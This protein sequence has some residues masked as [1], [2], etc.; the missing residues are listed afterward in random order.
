MKKIFFLTML[1]M[2]CMVFANAQRFQVTTGTS[3]ANEKWAVVTDTF[4]S[5]AT[6]YVAIGNT[7]NVDNFRQIWISSYTT[8]GVMVTSALASTGRQIIARDI[9][10]APLDATTGKRSYYVTGWTQQPGSVGAAA[11]NQMFVG[12]IRLDGSFIWYQE[13]PIS[14]NGNHIEGVAVVMAPNGDAVAVGNTY[15]PAGTITA[16]SRITLSRFSAAGAIL[17]SKVYNQSGN[18]MAR[19]I[20]MGVPTPNC[21]ASPTTLPGEFVVTGEANIATA[22][23]AGR[24]TA[25]VSAYNGAGTECWKNL[26]PATLTA[27][28]ITGD[29]GYDIVLNPATQNYAIA[30]VAQTGAVRASASSTPYLFEVTS[31][32]VITLGAVYLGPNNNPLGIYPRCIAVGAGF[33]NP[34]TNGTQLVIAG[35]DYGTNRTFMARIPSVGAVGSFNNYNG[36]AT[37]N[38]LAQPFILNDAQPEGILYSKLTSKPGYFVST[39]AHPVGAFGAGDAHFI[40]TDLNGQTPDDCKAL[41]IANIALSSKASTVAQSN[42]LDLQLW[43]T[44]TLFNQSLAVQQR[45]CNDVCNV[46]SAY[47]FTQSGSAVSFTGTGTGNGT[48]TYNWN[49]GDGSTSTLQN[50][51]HTYANGSFTACLTVINTNSAGDTCSETICKQITV[52]TQPCDVKASFTYKVTCKY[53]V[54]F[55]NTSTGTPTL[56]YKW[57]FGDGTFSTVKNPIKTF[58]NCGLH[59]V[60]LVTCN[61]ICCDTF[62]ATIDIPCCKVVSDFCLQDSGLYVK[63]LYSTTMNPSPTVYT[64]Y[65]DG[66]ATAWTAN[67]NKL[68]TAGL[69]TICLKASRSLCPGDTCCSTCCKTIAV[70]TPCTVKADFWYQVQSTGNVVFTNKST[71]TGY[72]SMWNFGDGSPVSTTA[73]PSHIYTTPGTYLVCLTSMIVNGGD[74]CTSRICK[75]IV[76]DQPCKTYAKFK[77]KYCLSTPL[78][79]EFGNYSTGAVAYVWDFGDGST[80]VAVSPI[81]T[82]SATGTYTVCLTAITNDKCWAKSCFKIVVTNSSCDTSCSTLPQRP[83]DGVSKQL[84]QPG[85]V[86]NKMIFEGAVKSENGVLSNNAEKPQP[87]TPKPE[88]ADKLSLFPNP[89]A[90]KVQLVFETVTEAKGEVSVINSI[91]GLVYRKS[92]QITGGKNQISVPVNTFTDGNYFVRISAGNKI[93][94]A[95]FTVK[96]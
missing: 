22:T 54:S 43:G 88:I 26:Y 39:N 73:S 87:E 32:G 7:T 44:K 67:T 90:Q 55:T 89:A 51:S 59:R 57:V 1:S 10:L 29:A 56:T 23:G 96:N 31:S 30:G 35:P 41:Q 48:L 78:T 21:V 36:L 4:P 81:H 84:L 33:S 58:A 15:L 49:F 77:T 37:A 70:R 76:I 50:P 92:I 65:V 28:N 72:A 3:Q 17:W 40:M 86:V 71:P 42:P 60:Y 19:E 14:P 75:T 83:I 18:W 25:F 20:A 38:S 11:M 82:Y 13:N 5:G 34:G 80:S 93:H 27:L 52:Q 45:F 63:L 61:K 62:Y 68:L 6:G 8:N 9:C 69:H 16:G 85:E 53:K 12:R 46:T 79:V 2:M 74:T 47:T 95:Q 91:G 64:V 94:T 24:A 66:V